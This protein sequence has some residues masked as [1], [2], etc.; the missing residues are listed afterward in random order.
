MIIR[1][2]DDVCIDREYVVALKRTMV[3]YNRAFGLEIYMK[4]GDTI[5][6]PNEYTQERIDEIITIIVGDGKNESE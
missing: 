4:N 6:L 1:V 3:Y 2:S 5:I